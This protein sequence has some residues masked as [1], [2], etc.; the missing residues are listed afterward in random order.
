MAEKAF[1]MKRLND[2]IQYLKKID[3]A[4]GGKSDFQ[5]TSHQDCQLGQWLYNE[6]QAEVA[7]L[8]NEN[9]KQVFESLLEPHERFHKLGQE[10][11]DNKQAGDEKSAQSNLTQMHILSAI[12]TNKLLQLDGM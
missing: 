7:A 12:L 1:F 6:G 8:E 3:A 4:I 11:L 5:G 9:V 2:H 10:A